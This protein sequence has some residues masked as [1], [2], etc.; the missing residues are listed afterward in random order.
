MPYLVDIMDTYNDPA[1]REVWVMKS[2]QVAWTEALN[3]VIGYA[4]D[5]KPGPLMI[6]QPTVEM[7][8]AW[9]KD[10][11]TPM[12]QDSPALKGKVSSPRAKDGA[13]TLRHKT[14]PGW[15]LT[16]A[17]ANSPAGLRMR[18]IRDLFCD[19]VDAYPRSIGKE[20]DPI[21]IARKRQTTFWN[22]KFFAGSTP[23][24][25]GASRIESGFESTDA[26]FMHVPC[27][28]CTGANGGKP[29]GYQRLVWQQVKW[30]EGKPREAAYVCQHCGVMIEHHH[31]H[32]MLE[33]RRWVATKPFDGR[34][35][36]HLSELYSPFVTWGEMAANYV[37]AALLPD[38][39][40]TF[41]NTSLGETY[42]EKGSTIE[43]G[44]LLDR[45][46]QYGADSIPAAVLMLTVGGDVQDDRVELQL[47]GWGAEEECWIMEQRVFRGDPGEAA[48]WSE[49]DDYLRSRFATEDG[50]LLMIQAAAIDSGGHNTQAV[51][52]FAAPRKRRRIW[53]IR[54]VGGA[55][56]LIWPRQGS[57]TAKSRALVYN[58]G[59]DAAKSL[60]YGRLTKV[61]TPGPGYI[62]LHADADENFCK[63]LTSEKSV[64][65]YVQGRPV[66][67]WKPRVERAPQEAQ[68]CWL[69]GYAAFLGRRGPE[70]IR[71]LFMRAAARSRTPVQSPGSDEGIEADALAGDAIAQ[72]EQPAPA[73]VQQPQRAKP[74]W[75]KQ[76]RRKN[77]V[78]SW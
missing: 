62:H 69:Y 14:G 53:A 61:P 40:Q 76:T 71:R 43:S 49:I 38:T 39:L 18:S 66:I 44:P 46:E 47:L 15:R 2:A 54:G 16:M 37:Q 12:L 50:R 31:K 24:V 75:S 1:V 65:K 74:H 63:Q 48:L 32:W 36:F 33:R 6:I 7:V 4:I 8:E 25:K 64:T 35:G 51:Y 78:R 34:A 10:R 73:H 9:S 26:R 3:N 55:G 59:V 20:G 13:N 23:T 67:V 70:I 30:P 68:D 5:R 45:R 52:N 11:L 22:A 41:V 77:W 58:L 27:P 42:E 57:R 17:G 28:H 19:E 60:L 72:S 21:S 29:D 56:K